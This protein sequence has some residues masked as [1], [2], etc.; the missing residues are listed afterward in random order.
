LFLRLTLKI[1]LVF[2]NR[3]QWYLPVSNTEKVICTIKS[4]TNGIKQNPYQK[5]FETG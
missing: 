4:F 5:L 3:V 2:K 1:Q